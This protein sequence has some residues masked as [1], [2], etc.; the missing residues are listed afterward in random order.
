MNADTSA[1]CLPAATA[2]RTPAL[3]DLLRDWG[4]RHAPFSDHDKAADLFPAPSQREALQLLDTTAALRGLMVLTGP[5][6]SGKSALLKSWL[7][8]L[9][10]KRESDGSGRKRFSKESY[11]CVR[12][13]RPQSRSALTIR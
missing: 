10:P 2:A 13:H 11:H 7:P 1:A 4:L 9:E 3:E 12:R 8:A 6:G 5:P